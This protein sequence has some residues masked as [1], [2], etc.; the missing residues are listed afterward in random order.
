MGEIAS[1]G[2]PHADNVSS[3]IMGF[4][5]IVISSNPLKIINLKLPKN[6]EFAIVI[7]EISFDTGMARSVLPKMIKLSDLV[8]NVGHAAA[9][10]SGI[11]LNDIELMG[12]GMN[13]CVIENSRSSLIPGLHKVK[14]AALLSGAKGVAI[15][16][17]G[18]SI[19]ALV[20]KNKNITHEVADAM[21]TTFQRH[22]IESTLFCSKPGS[23]AK[24]TNRTS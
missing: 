3:A 15:S 1:A 11:I 22:G 2:A 21:K 5:T 6:V 4:F 14:K 7:P 16:G 13:D 9:F 12:K 8:Y 19:L 10:M 24:I 17:A 18:P 23:G 20:D